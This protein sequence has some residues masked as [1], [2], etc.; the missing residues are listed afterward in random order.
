MPHCGTANTG[1]DTNRLRLP[2]R[3]Q[4]ARQV[5]LTVGSHRLGRRVLALQC[6]LQAI[7]CKG[8]GDDKGRVVVRSWQDVIQHVRRDGLE[9]GVLGHKREKNR[10]LSKFTA[11]TEQAHTIRQGTSGQRNA[12]WDAAGAL[13]TFFMYRN[14]SLPRKR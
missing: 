1:K 4:G 3:L 2:G 14:A 10:V 9:E 5:L 8:V 12:N 6:V 13:H 7:E 11:P